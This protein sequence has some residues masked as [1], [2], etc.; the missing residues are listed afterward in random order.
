MLSVECTGLRAGKTCHKEWAS[1]LT[2]VAGCPLCTGTEALSV[3]ATCPWCGA[4]HMTAWSG[5][6][7]PTHQGAPREAQG[8]PR[9][10]CDSCCGLGLARGW[11]GAGARR[12]PPR[13]DHIFPRC[14]AVDSLST[15]G[16]WPDSSCCQC[17]TQPCPSSILNPW[18]EP[19]QPNKGAGDEGLQSGEGPRWGP[20]ATATCEPGA[21]KFL[22]SETEI[23]HLPPG[24]GLDLPPGHTL[25]HLQGLERCPMSWVPVHTHTHTLTQMH[26]HT[27]TLTQM[28]ADTHTLTQTHAH[29]RTLTQMH[30]HTYTVMHAIQ[31]HIK[32]TPASTKHNRDSQTQ[33]PQNSHSG[34]TPTNKTHS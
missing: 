15:E 26:A 14:M 25:T 9:G 23:P 13:G 1:P 29:T 20:V 18:A 21:G 7:A 12:W 22:G 30:T 10:G 28:H 3:T 5:K 27:H 8:R 31:A 2:K 4:L 17:P 6:G 34:S 24:A 11:R 33:D 32:S 19:K 16:H